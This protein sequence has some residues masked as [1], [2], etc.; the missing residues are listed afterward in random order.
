M[1]KFY[2][3]KDFLKKDISIKYLLFKRLCNFCERKIFFLYFNQ[4]LFLKRNFENSYRFIKKT[5]ISIQFFFTTFIH[6]FFLPILK[7]NP[8]N[9]IKKREF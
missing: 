3:K 2:L 8:N 1:F 6:F 5:N 4:T 7:E 9:F